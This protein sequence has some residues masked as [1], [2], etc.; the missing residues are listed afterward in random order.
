MGPRAPYFFPNTPKYFVLNPLGSAGNH[1]GNHG[2]KSNIKT[3]R[4][5]YFSSSSCQSSWVCQPH[6]P[7]HHPAQVGLVRN[8]P[9]PKWARAQVGRGQGGPGPKWA[10]PKWVWAQVGP[11]PSGP[12]PKWAGPA[13]AHHPGRQDDG[14][15]SSWPSCTGPYTTVLSN[16]F[17]S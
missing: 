14:L 1:F 3:Y 16:P 17:Q 8:G 7:G 15:K 5:G 12:G 2:E 13:Q 10:R 11:G 6:H 4:H 9:R